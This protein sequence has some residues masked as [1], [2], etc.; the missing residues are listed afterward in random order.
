MKKY[1]RVL[2]TAD[3]HSSNH[4]PYS[5]PMENS[6][7]DRLLD[8][9]EVIHKIINCAESYKAEAIF[10]LGDTFDRSLVDAV[11]LT[12]TIKALTKT[13]IPI[14]VLPG[15]HDANSI[16]GG[17]FLVEA[18][19]AIKHDKLKYLDKDVFLRDWLRFIPIP[20]M[21]IEE[22]E[23]RIK[24]KKKEINE[25]LVNV[26]LFHNSILG[27]EHLEWVCD[28]GLDPELL[29]TD[30]N[31]AFGGHFHRPQSF[32]KNN[33]GFYVGAPLHHSFGDKDRMAGFSIVEF[34]KDGKIKKSFI[35]SEAPSFHTTDKLKIG[36]KWQ[37]GDYVRIIIE[38]THS[39]WITKKPQVEMFCDSMEGINISYKH[40][41]IYHHK[42]R[43]ASSKK[44]EK[45]TLEKAL[46]DYV[47]SSEVVFG[48]LNRDILKAHGNRILQE[49][50]TENGII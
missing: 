31:Y 44:E 48:D 19:G 36:D 29:T 47:V 34:H 7:T 42:K 35:K 49:V 30:F 5:K 20:F 9:L 32:G 43:L 8:L 28:D 16:R 45:I 23:N 15:N 4:L 1:C 6:I 27:C 21:T 18:F 24:E 40:K 46:E 2:F 14:Y 33:N 22:T 11:T 39:D 38:C 50:R 17:R 10:I 13:T 41:P 12:H 25:K 37:V 3:L 26:L